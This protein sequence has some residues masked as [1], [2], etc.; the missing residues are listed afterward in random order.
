MKQKKKKFLFKKV[1]TGFHKYAAIELANWVKGEI[2]KPLYL[3]GR[4]LVVP[5][6]I[7]SGNRFFEVKYKNG[8]TGKKLGLYQ[9]WSYRNNTP[10]SVYEIDAM[11]ILSH[12]NNPGVIVGADCY[13]FE[14]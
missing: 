12:L 7:A 8:L 4:I 9:Y 1:E 11:Y 5:D 13:T 10:I 14:S 6:V 3:D 2:E